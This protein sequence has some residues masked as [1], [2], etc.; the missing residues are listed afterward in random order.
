MAA[1]SHGPF[2]FPLSIS[3]DLVATPELSLMNKSL[4]CSQVP[5]NA[6]LDAPPSLGLCRWG[7]TGFAERKGLKMC[8]SLAHGP[9]CAMGDLG[10]FGGI[11]DGGGCKGAIL[12]WPDQLCNPVKPPV[13]CSVLLSCKFVSL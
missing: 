10:F 13:V 2:I 12:P 5:P 11:P 3:L 6:L 1:A 8:T 7:N 9:S 4:L